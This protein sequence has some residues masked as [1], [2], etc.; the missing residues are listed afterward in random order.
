VKDFD[1]NVI[2]PA[3]LALVTWLW[4][5]RSKDKRATLRDQIDAV[6]TTAVHRIANSAELRDH[7]RELL[8]T[9]AHAL[10]DRLGIDPKPWKSLIRLA[11]D[12]GLAEL[13]ELLESRRV[14]MQDAT[15]ALAAGAQG[16][17][18]AFDPPTNPRVPAIDPS[19]VVFEELREPPVNALQVYGND[20]DEPALPGMDATAA[21]A[22]V[23]RAI[24][25]DPLP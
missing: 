24:G 17:V 9:E 11:V 6:I 3:I 14:A 5:S 12:E 18:D 10:L 15:S 2:V 8:T 20:P 1:P 13:A 16:V 23:R 22:R 4:Q 21:A 19:V 25:K 7:A